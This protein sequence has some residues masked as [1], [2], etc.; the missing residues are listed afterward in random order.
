MVV[1]LQVFIE[2]VDAVE[3]DAEAQGPHGIFELFFLGDPYHYYYYLYKPISLHVQPT[4]PNL[5]EKNT[6]LPSLSIRHH[7]LPPPP[8]PTLIHP[9]R[10]AENPLHLL[11][12]RGLPGR[13]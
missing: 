2:A 9:M 11:S 6:H 7:R 1:N 13:N 10:T 8:A 5:P 4:D 3:E 12:H